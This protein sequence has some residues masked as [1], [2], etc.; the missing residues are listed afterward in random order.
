M[1]GV[2]QAAQTGQQ[3]SSNSVPVVLSADQS[4]IP[5]SLGTTVVS[6]S[7]VPYPATT[8]TQT[9]VAA[10]T[11]AGTVLASNANRLGAAVYNDSTGTLYMLAAAG[12]ASTTAY[13]V[14]MAANSYYETPFRY[15]GIITGVWTVSSGAARV[16]AY[17][18]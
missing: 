4:P 18:S 7:V 3:N 17:T 15:T 9:S 11:T 14:Q 8:G 5:I 13:T 16:T 2:S 6:I 10:S 12:T 1:S